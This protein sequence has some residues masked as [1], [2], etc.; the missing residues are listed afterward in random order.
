MARRWAD[1]GQILDEENEGGR[2]RKRMKEKIRRNEKEEAYFAAGI[3][4]PPARATLLS[5]DAWGCAV[6]PSSSFAS[7]SL[8]LSLSLSPFC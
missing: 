5:G 1:R 2:R 4:A 7:F 8:P 6:P 3:S